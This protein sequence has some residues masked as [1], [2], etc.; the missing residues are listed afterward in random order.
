[1]KVIYSKQIR[2]K[3]KSAHCIIGFIFLLLVMMSGSFFL[4][5][6]TYANV[7]YNG[8]LK[9]SGDLT[10]RD[11]I[12]A[13]SR[14]IVVGDDGGLYFSSNGSNWTKKGLM[15][16]VSDHL[17][18][19]GYDGTNTVVAVGRDQLILCSDDGGD[20]WTKVHDRVSNTPDIYKVA[21]GN[22]KWI[23]IDESGGIWTS[24]NGKTGWT[25]YNT[26]WST[27]ARRSLLMSQ[28]NPNDPFF[29]RGTIASFIA[30]VIF[31][32]GFWLAL[33]LLM[34]HRG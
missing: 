2:S 32:S 8:A 23:A 10:L 26:N 34:A 6:Q 30:M 24:A 18:G 11:V 16:G 3:M 1:M 31:Y 28:S 27:S 17:F 7:W 14:F 21:Y 5:A 15:I 12:W 9:P 19:V 29:P 4:H 33:Y 20:S 22:E 25:K 13:G